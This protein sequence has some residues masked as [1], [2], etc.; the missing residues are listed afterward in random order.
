M[1]HNV[2]PH[3]F[4]SL[5][6][7]GKHF[8]NRVFSSGHMAVML[9]DGA[10]SDRMIAYHEAKA[11][12]GAAL[13]IL[14]AARVHETGVS[15]R[16]SI[17]AFLDECV[18]GYRR[19][20]DACHAYDCLVIAQLSHPGREMA[21]AVDGTLSVAYAPSAI[22]N[23]RFHMMPREL[24]LALIDEIIEGFLL[25][26]QRMQTAGLDG[27]EIVASHGNL[28]AQF[29][30]P[31]V[32]QR[33]DRYGGSLANRMTF[34]REIL[35]ATRD[36]AGKDMI[37]GMRISVDELEYQGLEQEEM[38]E[39]V[40]TLN[41]EGLLDY[42]GVTVGTSAGLSGST[43]I[44]PSMAYESAYV[45]PFS[46]AVKAKVDIPVLVAG[47]I[48][49]PQ[50]AEQVIRS[51]QAD[52]C[53]MTR[54]IICDPDM[55][56][57]SHSGKLDEIRACIAC[58]QACI[59]HMLKGYPI[60]CIQNPVTGRELEL[61]NLQQAQKPRKVM[62]VGGGPAGM[63]AAIVAAQR[64][65]EVTLYEA[66][67]RLGGQVNLAQRL[68]GRG[69]FGGLVTNLQNE[70]TKTGV[71]VRTKQHVDRAL[72]EQLAPDA[73]VIATGAVPYRPEIEG[74]ETAHVI[75]AWQ[76]IQ[77][78]EKAGANV[79]I[80]DWRGDWIGM[81]L[82]E[83]LAREGSH[84]RLSVN[85]ITPGQM[86]PQYVRDTWLGELHKLGVE[87]MPY[88][89]LFGMDSDTVYL[90]HTLSKAAVVCDGVDTVVL[91][92]GHRPETGLEQALSGWPGEVH[93]IGD[94]LS[95][96]TAEEAVL[97]GLRVGVLL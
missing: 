13:T 19:L 32:N 76:V 88:T 75:D 49:Q 5:S 52:M 31:H 2:F 43:H 58:N 39:V 37:V 72:V 93:I 86:I 51:N 78:E 23:E 3:L 22:P 26:S 64:S 24:P 33:Q 77:G 10:I 42:I 55:P 47:R 70:L 17:Y 56:A 82:A 25:A 54:A 9:E 97:E 65:H 45:A 15:S 92:L 66:S 29:L 96:R 48:N 84:V 4:S 87:I 57:K 80:A 91:A 74:Q 94:C 61:G 53:A 89:R 67:S 71:D 68:P 35:S 20:V 28:I 59:G 44:V 27:I 14:E 11:K 62:V 50:I 18:D 63:K 8:K 69:E 41:S 40:S 7:R 73:V 1:T 38:L 21:E 16:P 12:G 81:G 36:G 6:I 34:L 46:Q 83:K 85:G 79:V 30:N 60:S 95:P 90:Q